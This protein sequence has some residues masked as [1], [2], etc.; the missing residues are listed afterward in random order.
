MKKSILLFVLCFSLA[1][2]FAQTGS[3]T[4]PQL[5]QRFEQDLKLLKERYP[6]RFA[7]MDEKEL[8]MFREHEMQMM[9]LEKQGIY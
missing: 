8:Q 1:S 9:Q 4:N 3:I 7:K 5:E 2:V 6:K